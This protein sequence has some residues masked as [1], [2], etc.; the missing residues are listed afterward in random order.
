MEEAGLADVRC[1]LF[2]FGTMAIHV[3]TRPPR[4]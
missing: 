3:G 1:H 4:S 2:M